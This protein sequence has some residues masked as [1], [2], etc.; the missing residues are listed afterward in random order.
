MKNLFKKF[1][2]LILSIEAK[3]L[4]LK[5]KPTI[6]CITGSVGKTTTKDAIYAAVRNSR[7][8]RKSEKSYNSE[9]GVPLT[10]LGL[11]NAWNNPFLWLKNIIEGAFMVFFTRDYPDVLILETG[12]DKPGDMAKLTTW[13]KPDIVVLTRLPNVPVHVENFSS[14]EAVVAEK[15]KLVEALKPDGVLVYNH[16]DDIIKEQ[17]PNVRQKAIGY[18]RYLDSQFKAERDRIFYNDDIPKGT[19]FK[20]KHLDEAVNVKIEGVIGTQFVYTA[21]GAIAVAHSLDVPLEVAA[22]SVS[23]LTAPPGRMNIIPGIKGTT[24]IDDSYNSSPIATKAALECLNEVKHAKRKVAVLGD[25][26]ELGKYSTSQ[27]EEIGEKIPEVA[28][29]MFTVG[30]RARGFASG[31]M[32]AGLSEEKVFQYDDGARAGRELQN[33]IQPGDLILI[34]GSEGMRMEKIVEEI[35]SEPETAGYMLARQNK[36]WKSR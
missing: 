27:H 29:I 21:L 26:L 30:V 6:V 19:S 15:M 4:I 24:I 3:W 10:V 18:S 9:I 25:M 32:S 5:M 36:E 12:V 8:A 34:K 17:L 20:V 2:V 7:S 33:F 23:E 16:D 31:A 22:S 35:M 1:V 11:P 13:L 28:D 14:P